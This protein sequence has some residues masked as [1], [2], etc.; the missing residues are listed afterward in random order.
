MA[1]LAGAPSR[2]RALARPQR[3]RVC[4]A[5]ASSLAA[6]PAAAARAAFDAATAEAPL[7]VV[8]VGRDTAL[9]ANVGALLG[10]ELGYTPLS[11]TELLAGVA[12]MPV[13][14]LVQA[15]GVDAAL[16]GEGSVFEALSTQIRLVVST[17][18]EGATQR[19]DEW[20]WLHGGVVVHVTTGEPSEHAA[21]MSSRADCEARHA[22][23]ASPEE[24]LPAVFDAMA[25]AVG[26][27]EE[28]VKKKTMYIKFGC[29]GDWPELKPPG[30]DPSKPDEIDPYLP[31]NQRSGAGG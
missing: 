31:K 19:A 5:R 4:R 7:N 28:L 29:R 17:W 16:A 27:N 18:G 10:A 12:N 13:E 25:G 1:A 22:L 8:L 14:E 11:T 24:V 9:L 21:L 6:A 15:Q 23:G 20:R 30:W 2:A 26:A 3:Q